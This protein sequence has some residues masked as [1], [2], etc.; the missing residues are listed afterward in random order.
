M[1]DR[2]TLS[3]RKLLRVLPI[4]VLQGGVHLVVI[5]SATAV[6][7]SC[8]KEELDCK[9]TSGLS[10]AAKQLRTALEY[11]DLSPQGEAKDCANCQ[12]YRPARK[13]ECGACTLVQGP[14]NPAGY[15]NSWAPKE[16]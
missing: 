6:L 8:S 14:I 11:Q 15:C 12:F 10:T 13:N 4:Q 2:M 5:A 3:R 9:D 7:A 16:S 1:K